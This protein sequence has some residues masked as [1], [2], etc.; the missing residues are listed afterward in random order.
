[1]QSLAVH[2]QDA[3]S[4][5][6]EVKKANITPTLAIVFGSVAV[7]WSPILAHFKAEN[8]TFFGATSAGEVYEGEVLEHS[9]TAILMNLSPSYFTLIAADK[10][11]G[12]SDL[13]LGQ[14]LGKKAKGA[15]SKPAVLLH[16]S[17]IGNDAELLVQGMQEELG[18]DAPLFGGLAGDDFRM[19]GTFAYADTEKIGNGAATLV[20]DTEKV[21]VTGLATSGWEAVSDIKKVTKAEGNIVY[22]LDNQPIMDVFRKLF[23]FPEEMSPSEFVELVGCQTPLHVHRE[24]GSTV[25]RAS[26]MQNEEGAFIFAG[27][28]PEGADVQL[29]IPPSLQITETALKELEVLHKENEKPGALLMYSCKARHISLDFM[30]EEE[31]QGIQDLWPQVP[32]IGFFSYGEIGAKPGASCDFHNET[33][34][35][36]A[37][38]ER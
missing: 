11:E 35:V 9:I 28:V 37:I 13:Q 2:G 1:M 10:E 25:I 32:F 38:S 21:A 27:S 22:E 16:A 29:S 33:L 36:V 19:E 23:T 31:T 24:D 18:V 6:A 3:T 4:F 8:C 30:I 15:F 7:D 26:L 20:F 34:S 12:Q 5:L 14:L 17:G